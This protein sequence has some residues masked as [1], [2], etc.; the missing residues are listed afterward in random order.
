MNYELLN[1]LIREIEKEK[2][3][4]NGEVEYTYL[5][6]ELYAVRNIDGS[7]MI[8]LHARNPHEACAKYFT[9]N[10]NINFTGNNATFIKSVDN[11][12]LRRK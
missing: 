5:Q 9:K 10:H 6:E 1:K 7:N 3:F 11:L 12:D 4:P 2:F 8:L